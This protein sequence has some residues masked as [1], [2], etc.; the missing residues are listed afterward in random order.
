MSRQSFNAEIAVCIALIILVIITWF[1]YASFFNEYVTVKTAIEFIKRHRALGESPQF[2]LDTAGGGLAQPLD[3][4][5]LW[6]EF[7]ASIG[8]A[9]ISILG[10][11]WLTLRLWKLESTRQSQQS[12]I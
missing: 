4:I 10:L 1:A 6:R 7:Q 5:I 12:E 9:I 3:I 2:I 11:T 8:I